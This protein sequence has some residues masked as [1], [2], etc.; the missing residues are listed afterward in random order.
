MAKKNN[1]PNIPE[2]ECRSGYTVTQ[3]EEIMGDRAEEFVRWMSG[4]T[5]ALCEGKKYNHETKKY[6]KDCG[7]TS[8][9]VV[10]YAWDLKRFL[11]IYGQAAKDLW[12]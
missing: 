5:V 8:H 3:V 7:G 1:E 4:Q 11:G 10:I 12:D 6:E 2:P 9:G